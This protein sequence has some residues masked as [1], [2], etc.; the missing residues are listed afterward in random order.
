M[1]IP[2]VVVDDDD[3]D[4]YLVKRVIKSLGVDAKLIEYEDGEAFTEVIRDNSRSAIEIGDPPPPALV[5][6]DINMPRM[7]GF[8]V[9]EAMRDLLEEENQV[10]FVTMYS[11]SSQAQERADAEKYPFVHDYIVKPLSEEKLKALIERLYPQK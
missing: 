11:S 3:V 1:T 2:I 6:L 4:R 8:Q 9:L 5:L 10:M 7:G